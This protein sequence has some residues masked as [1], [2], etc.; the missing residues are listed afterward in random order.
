[1]NQLIINT[2]ENSKQFA[3][4]KLLE[5]VSGQGNLADGYLYVV[6]NSI[7]WAIH[8]DRG[9]LFFA[10][11]NLEPF[12]RLERHLRRLSHEVKTLDSQVRTAVRLNFES[13]SKQDFDPYCDYRAISWLIENN[14]IR[15]EQASK[16]VKQITKEVFESYLLLEEGEYKF[17]SS[18]IEFNVF[19]EF[20][21]NQLVDECQKNLKT[22]QSLGGKIYS[23]YQRP[24]FFSQNQAKNKLPQ[25]LQDKLGKILR[26]FNFRQL[27]SLLNQ[28]ELEIAKN[29]RSLINN[30]VIFLRDPQPPFDRLP[31]LKPKE[32]TIA[33]EKQEDKKNEA[34]EKTE[35]EITLPPPQPAQPEQ[36]EKY[37]IACID[38]S[39]TILDEINRFL[40]DRTISVFA[41]S[42]PVKALRDI[43]R[44]KPDLILLDVGMPTIDGYNLCRLIR[45]HSLFKNTPV[46]MVTGNTGIIDRAK[47]RL[48]GS[49]DYL[50]KP[51]TQS[52]LV[53]M[54]HKYLE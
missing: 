10:T 25:E 51:F 34:P 12:E 54:V 5:F 41:I 46:V 16:L 33:P 38:D 24:Y 13:S 2:G 19:Q 26:G 30:G 47:A 3:P 18:P 42:D 37:K 20:E 31:L 48:A 49:T 27:S 17:K 36:I 11:N 43:I 8:F 6:S 39:P 7:D 52:Q 32:K 21:W 45:N 29:L 23:P 53:K 9:K 15:Y 40:S 35:A 14:Y 22:W 44:I 50:T 28:D 4:T 1:M